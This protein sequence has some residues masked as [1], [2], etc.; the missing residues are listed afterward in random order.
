MGAVVLANS[1]RMGGREGLRKRSSTYARQTYGAEALFH[2]E[3][4]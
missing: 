2:I 4:E 1:A 3:V